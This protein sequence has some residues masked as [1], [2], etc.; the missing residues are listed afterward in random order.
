MQGRMRLEQQSQRSDFTVTTNCDN[1]QFRAVASFVC[2]VEKSRRQQQ[3]ALRTD[4]SKAHTD[5]TQPSLLFWFQLKTA[6]PGCM[7]GVGL[8]GMGDVG[9]QCKGP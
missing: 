4:V 6:F 9:A 2:I 1:V 5:K 3:M 8:R 7:D